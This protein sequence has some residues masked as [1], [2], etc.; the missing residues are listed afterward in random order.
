MSSKLL[1][2]KVRRRRGVLGRARRIAP[3]ERA[4]LNPHDPETRARIMNPASDTCAK[5][6]PRATSAQVRC[7]ES[8]RQRPLA[9]VRSRAEAAVQPVPSGKMRKNGGKTVLLDRSCGA[10]KSL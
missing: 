4:G 5:S 8:R 7:P 2:R 1:Q 6:W 3:D 9:R 10:T